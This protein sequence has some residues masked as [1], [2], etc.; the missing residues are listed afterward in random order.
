MT[1]QELAQ[2]VKAK[3]PEL[4]G[5]D[6]ETVVAGVLEQT[7]EYSA[8]LTDDDIGS[9]VVIFSKLII[10]FQQVKRKY[11]TRSKNKTMREKKQT[12]KNFTFRNCQLRMP[13][14]IVVL[15]TLRM[16]CSTIGRVGRH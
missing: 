10:T 4:R 12:R 6:D 11:S 13:R 14:M 15:K 2:K 7:P 16:I 9:N 3:Y 8:Y 1:R 5:F